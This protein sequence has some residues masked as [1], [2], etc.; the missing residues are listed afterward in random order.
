MT[1]ANTTREIE[2]LF[3]NAD[4]KANNIKTFPQNYQGKI[5]DNEFVRVNVFQGNSILRYQGDQTVNGFVL[6]NIFVPVG[7]GV[8]RAHEIADLLNTLLSK[9]TISGVQLTNSFLTT[10]GVDTDNSGLFRLDYTINFNN[11]N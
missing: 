11:Y 1:F 7:Q 4:W 2:K 10:V 6:C 5:D 3:N 8:K 9:K